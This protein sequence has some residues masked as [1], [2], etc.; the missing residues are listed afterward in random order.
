MSFIFQLPPPPQQQQQQQT[1]PSAPQAQPAAPY[2]PSSVPAA[3]P[4]QYSHPPPYGGQ[5]HGGQPRG[6]PQ[7]GPG[8]NTV[9]IRDRDDGGAGGFANG[10]ILGTGLG[11][12]AGKLVKFYRKI[13]GNNHETYFARH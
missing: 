8:Q 10:M 12:M 2:V 11:L 4:P 3:P 6:H 1:A 13:Y 5:Q 7:N 9:I